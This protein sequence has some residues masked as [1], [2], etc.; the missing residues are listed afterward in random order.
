M[1]DASYS[2][3]VDIGTSMIIDALNVNGAVG[4][5]YNANIVSGDA[6]ISASVY[7]AEAYTV[8]SLW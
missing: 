2:T 8:V 6:A 4:F 5:E 1:N 3:N 7:K